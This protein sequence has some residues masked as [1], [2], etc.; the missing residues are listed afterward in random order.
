MIK[1]LIVCMFPTLGIFACV[2]SIK[3]SN[4]GLM[5]LPHYLVEKAKLLEDIQGFTQILR[6]AK[7][8][9]CNVLMKRNQLPTT[10]F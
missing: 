2:G 7:I 1:F 3:S 10:S 8:Q 6:I 4:C 9:L 5:Q